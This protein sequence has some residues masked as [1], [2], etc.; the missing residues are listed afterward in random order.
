MKD[1]PLPDGYIL[2]SDAVTR[3]AEGIWGGLP[4][5]EPLRAIKTVAKKASIGFGP[6]REFAGRHLTAA[7]RRGELA[8]YVAAGAERLAQSVRGPHCYSRPVLVPKSILNRLITSRGALSD[9]PIRPTLTTAGGD[10]RLFALLSVGTLVVRA[11]DFAVWY[12]TD[13]S[14]GKWPS[15]R[16]STKIRVGRPSRQTEALRNAIIGLVRRQEWNA[17]HGATRLRRLLVA[18]DRTDVPS[19]DTLT[20][21]IDQMHRERG[22][23]ELIR[24]RRTRRKTRAA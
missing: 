13:R 19:A 16:S 9:A 10:A 8:V 23:P 4:R 24:K 7:V 21:M 15:Q 14:K 22:E 6:W 2:L 12:E 20:R 17:Q 18:S 3:L 1:A 11:R 5:A